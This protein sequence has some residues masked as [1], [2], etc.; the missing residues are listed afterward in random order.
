MTTAIARPVLLLLLTLVACVASAT[1]TPNRWGNF[2]ALYDVVRSGL[3]VGEI[4]LTLEQPEQGRYR[5]IALTRPVGLARLFTDSA[6]EERSEGRFTK[7]GVQPESYRFDQTGKKKRSVH[8]HFDWQKGK[9]QNGSSEHPWSMEINTGI[10]DRFGHQL[11][12]MRAFAEGREAVELKVA[13]GG[14]AKTYRFKLLGTERIRTPAGEFDALKVQ[15]ATNNDPPNY[16]LW[17]APSAGFLPV[18][19]YRHDKKLEMELKRIKGK[20]LR[21]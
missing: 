8:I 14:S 7:Q 15:R 13:D 20:P 19:I 18:R 3:T 1:S 9:A 12:V 17:L 11:T 4:T 5:Y 2:T 21:G 16:T 6:V 10:Q